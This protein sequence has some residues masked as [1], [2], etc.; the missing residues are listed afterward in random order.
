M[1]AVLVFLGLAIMV[2]VLLLAGILLVRNECVYKYRNS[3]L[4]EVSAA[5]R[6]DIQRRDYTWQRRYDAFD[7][8]S[9]D[10]MVWQFWKR[11]RAF[12]PDTSFA[13]MSEKEVE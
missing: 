6:E 1:I 8:V 11:W 10:R 9:Y 5:T 12:Y 4:S 13:E 3:L 7:A 2:V